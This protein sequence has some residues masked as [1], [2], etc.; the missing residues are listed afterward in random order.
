MKIK[1]E[2][3][4]DLSL[5]KILNIHVSIIIVRSIFDF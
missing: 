2:S 4:D 3:K 1:F 5:G